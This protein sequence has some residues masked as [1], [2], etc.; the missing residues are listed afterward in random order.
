[1]AL[2]QPASNEDKLKE[3]DSVPLFMR[4]LP[5]LEDEA[6]D[7]TAINALQSLVYEGT[8]DE[9]A[10]NFKEQG[11]D[12]FKGKRYR[13]A[14]GFYTQGIDARPDD[15]SLTEILLC[16]RAACNLE[17]RN[18][19]SV[20]R[21]CSRAITLNPACLKAYYRSA[22]ALLALD[23]PDDAIDACHRCLRFDPD[24]SGIKKLQERALK[25]KDVKMEKEKITLERIEK[26]EAYKKRMRRA[27]EERGLVVV[28]SPSDEYVPKFD[29][30]GDDARSSLFLPTFF[31]YPQYAQ[32]DVVPDFHEDVMLIDQLSR[33]FPPVA[34]A[35]NWDTKHEYTVG[36][37]AVYA[38]THTKRLLRV[39][40][41]MTLRDVC[42]VAKSKDG[43][44]DGLDFRDGYLSFVVVPKGEVERVWIDEFKSNRDRAT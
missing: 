18:C 4:S 34:P 6:H 31:L 3:F 9:I 2:P 20:L 37:L 14:L 13:E 1:M 7:S 33:M 25:A 35:P 36:K 21:D 43:K 28:G 5:G 11:N 40:A 22:L 42:D 41:K 32:S 23:R 27:F 10:Q 17:L 8:P 29:D 44:P 24:N 19:G 30:R 39:G 38:V 15:V 16:N 26:E 12:Y